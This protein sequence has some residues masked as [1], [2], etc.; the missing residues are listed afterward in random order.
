M[1]RT[2]NQW[3]VA[4]LFIAAT[5][6]QPH[7]TND[8]D[9]F[10]PTPTHIHRTNQRWF[11]APLLIA[12]TRRQPHETT[13]TRHINTCHHYDNDADDEDEND[14]EKAIERQWERKEERESACFTIRAT[15]S[16]SKR[17][18][19]QKPAHGCAS[20]ELSVTS[21]SKMNKILLRSY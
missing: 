7:A 4:P 1:F 15:R 2:K 8:T 18:Q 6:R 9:D 19:M 17:K 20:L 10:Q 12:A 16:D 21:P 5:K 14:E 3:F 13:D 11:V